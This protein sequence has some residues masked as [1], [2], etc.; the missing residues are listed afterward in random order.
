MEFFKFIWDNIV[1]VI[2]TGLIIAGIVGFL[3]HL[4]HFN[5]LLDDG[6]MNIIDITAMSV[7]LVL[8][9]SGSILILYTLA[10]DYKFI[11]RNHKKE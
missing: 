5:V 1:Y 7:S 6:I 3:H 8:I 11:K 10:H 2:G 9:T 4:V